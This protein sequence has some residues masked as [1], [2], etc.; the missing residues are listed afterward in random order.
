[1][2]AAMWPA[3]TRR[4]DAGAQFKLRCGAVVGHG[5]AVAPGAVR[6]NEGAKIA[7]RAVRRRVQCFILSQMASHSVNARQEKG[8]GEAGVLVPIPGSADRR[9]RGR[10]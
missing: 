8:D 3:R 2:I 9:A 5:C 4:V 7:I 6:L 10:C 1:M